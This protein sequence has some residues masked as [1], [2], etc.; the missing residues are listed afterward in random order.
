MTVSATREAQAHVAVRIE[1]D[2][3]RMLAEE[4]PLAITGWRCG[5]CDHGG[6][7]VR[8]AI[9]HEDAHAQ[10]ARLAPMTEADLG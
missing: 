5:A 10:L 6:T 7:D 3:L 9:A 4:T 1:L 2:R 8:D